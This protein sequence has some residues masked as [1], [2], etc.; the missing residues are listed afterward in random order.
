ML[1]IGTLCAL[2]AYILTGA[3]FLHVAH[4]AEPDYGTLTGLLGLFIANTFVLGFALE[5]LLS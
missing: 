5:A 1:I 3:L 4:W 2:L